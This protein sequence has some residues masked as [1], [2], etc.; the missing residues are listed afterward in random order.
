MQLEERIQALPREL[1]DMILAFTIAVPT[2]EII[3]IS[4]EYEI[5]IGLQINR[6]LRNRN[7]RQYF[8]TNSFLWHSENS[9]L[10][11]DWLKQLPSEHLNLIETILIRTSYFP[12]L[13]EDYLML[14]N[15]CHETLV[16]RYGATFGIG[17]LKVAYMH[18]EKD[19]K[20]E[21]RW[22]SQSELEALP[23]D[24][25]GRRLLP[26]SGMGKDLARLWPPLRTYLGLS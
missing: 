2:G 14:L 21:V 3:D 23:C 4:F 26:G 12:R 8:G 18:V 11:H 17:I 7:L 19:G 25:N 16:S 20:E 5:P 6:K 24:E 13:V 10:F 9:Y 15:M 1:Q 22:I